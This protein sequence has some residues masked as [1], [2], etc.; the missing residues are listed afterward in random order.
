MEKSLLMIFC[1]T[2]VTTAIWGQIIFLAPKGVG[3]QICILGS[4]AEGIENGQK[5]PE[6]RGKKLLFKIEKRI[7]KGQKRITSWFNQVK[8]FQKS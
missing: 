1:T 6:K 5:G 7:Q 2:A 8:K 3:H 4:L